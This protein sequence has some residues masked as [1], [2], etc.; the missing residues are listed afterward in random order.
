MTGAT[1]NL[2]TLTN[3]NVI[4][5]DIKIQISIIDLD[6]YNVSIVYVVL[7]TLSFLPLASIIAARLGR[8]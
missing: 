7:D 1:K 3:T 6:F 2:K 5:T 4:A 8:H